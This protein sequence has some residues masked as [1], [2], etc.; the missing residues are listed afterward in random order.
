M[1]CYSL[2]EEPWIPVLSKAGNPYTLS[3]RN[4]L[5]EAHALREVFDP[6]PLVTV[7]I[8]RLLQA[9]LYRVFLPQSYADWAG[10]WRTG[11]IDSGRLDR[12]GALWEGRFDLIHPTRPF[13]QVPWMEDEKEH[14]ISALVLEAASG[15]NSTLFDHGKVEGMEAL[16]FDRAACHLM[17]QQLFAF[18]GG[19]SK[20]FNRRDAPLTK[21]LV[22][23]ARGRNVFETLL[24]NL[25]PLEYWSSF[26]PYS[27][28]DR[29]FWEIDSP[30]EPEREGSRPLGPIHY[31]TW[32]SRQIHLIVDKSTG[33]ATGCQI[34]QRYC[35]DRD[36]HRIDPGKVYQ[37]KERGWVPFKVNK[38]RAIWPSAHVLLQATD[39]DMARPHLVEWLAAVD[40]K[41]KLERLDV[42]AVIGMIVSGMATD[43]QKAA[44]IEIWRRE[45]LPIPVAFLEK[46]E[47]VGDLKD[48][49]VKARHVESLLRRTAEALV[50]AMGSR[51]ELPRALRHI[52]AGKVSKSKIY[53]EG[54]V[55][56]EK[57]NLSGS[58]GM[59]TRY[60]PVLE[61]PFRQALDELPRMEFAKVRENW[62]KAV[63]NAALQS[64][65]AA[66]DSLIHSEF[67]YE[68]LTH[69]EYNFK[70]CLTKTIAG[71]TEEVPSNGDESDE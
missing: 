28:R 45:Y 9:V 23:E 18:G 19:V 58:L 56:K 52:R 27:E 71:K 7:A 35:L 13:Y 3:L 40:E 47:L 38:Q 32:Q 69:I 22:A 34:K 17:V 66:R 55:P 26:I 57:K 68:T 41:G 39:A 12:Y 15:N 70:S 2:W 54:S 50:W 43:P 30:P 49:L 36:G 59:V 61:A 64:F 62:Q 29:P 14:P 8:H 10:L 24:L 33:T 37:H 51:Q 44:K 67:P 48:L 31:L 21:G 16:P 53:K 63:L 4:V 20:P 1:S 6:S 65:F 46:P 25:V 11:R 60:W 42:P 5:A